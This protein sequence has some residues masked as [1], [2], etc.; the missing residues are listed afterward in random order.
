MGAG[1]S[2]SRTGRARQDLIVL[3]RVKDGAALAQPVGEM[4]AGRV[5]EPDKWVIVAAE[6]GIGVYD[7]VDAVAASATARGLA[8][9][10]DA[11]R[12]AKDTG[13]GG[14]WPTLVLAA[15]HSSG[16]LSGTNCTPL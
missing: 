8:Q 6:L 7:G 4:L 2:G 5:A 10:V 13:G 16:A 11:L 15:S 12:Q 14:A 9:V 1:E 3:D